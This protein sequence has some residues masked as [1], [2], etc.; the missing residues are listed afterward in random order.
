MPPSSYHSQSVRVITRTLL[1]IQGLVSAA[2]ITSVTIGT[3]VGEDLSGK[4]SFAGI[5]GGVS[6]LGAAFSA[7]LWSFIFARLGKRAGLVLGLTVGASGAA[8]AAFAVMQRSFILLLVGL[9]IMAS[10]KASTDLGR[11]IA[12]EINPPQ[13]RGR[14]VAIVVL[15]GTLG[16]VLGPLLVDSSSASARSLGL[17]VL[18]GPYAVGALLLLLSAIVTFLYLRPSPESL[19]LE[20]A[21]HYPQEKRFQG[22]ARPFSV[23]FREPLII[24]AILSMILGYAV[25]AMMMGITSLHMRQHAHSL[26]AISLVFSVHTLGMFAFSMLT[27]QLVDRWGRQK[28]IVAGTLMLIASCV[29]APLSNNFWPIAIALF[30]LGLGWNFTYVGG[31][32]L[33][34]DQLSTAEKAATQG[35]NDMFIGLTSASV[36]ALSGFLLYRIGYGGMGILGGF[37]SFILLLIIWRFGSGPKL[38][39]LAMAND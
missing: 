38:D 19:A 30:L 1:A 21:E 37:L 6:Q 33:L 3:I 18:S 17:E 27:G 5:P 35:T 36:S 23:L 2:T 28:V 29:L 25:M 14:A 11:F 9:A 4:V 10:A 26:R 13:R 24:A 31:S 32:T 16:S 20:L 34:S 7:L 39:K 22:L 12:A 8:L 15:G